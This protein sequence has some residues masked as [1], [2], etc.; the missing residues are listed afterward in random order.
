MIGSTWTVYTPV[1]IG[2]ARNY[3]YPVTPWLLLLGLIAL[4]LANALF[5]AAE[6]SLITVDRPGVRAA[7]ER[8][9]RGA[10]SLDRAIKSLSTQLSGAQL[11][12]TVSSLV[13]GFISEPS[14]GVLLRGPLGLTGLPDGAVLAASVTAS[15]LIATV[16]Q[17][18]LGEL[19]PKNWALAQPVR[20]GKL[21]AT[22]NRAFTWVATPLLFVLQGSANGILRL[23]RIEPQE[24]LAS[25]RSG[26]ELSAMAIRSAFE[27][28]LE[29]K[30]AERITRS[31][32]LGERY[33]ADAMTPRAR[34]VFLNGEDSAETVLSRCRETGHS[35]FPVTGE[36][37]EDVVGAVHFRHA[38]EVPVEHRGEIRVRDIMGPLVAVPASMPLDNVLNELRGGLQFAVVVDEYDG[39]DGIITLEDLVEELVGEIDDEHD[40]R[41]SRHEKLE[42]GQWTVSGSLRPDEFTR[43]IG[44]ELPEGETTETLSGLITERLGRFPIVGDELTVSGR[45]VAHPDSD[46]VAERV[47]VE[48]EVLALAG[49]VVDKVRMDVREPVEESA[50]EEPEP[51]GENGRE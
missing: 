26:Q 2:W 27:G 9:E 41:G 49:H 20:L 44:V 6:F 47:I 33:A 28:D 23:M 40:P 1:L 35:R 45:D 31:A 43:L 50:E 14:L 48:L 8:N 42:N 17:M 46:G 18:V 39:T 13:V 15:F 4:V 36:D 34:V 51:V 25:A 21:V 29:P 7:I 16:A 5:V 32:A 12:I 19:V 38:L 22:A 10:K 24:E 11:G 30:V 3:P 37:V